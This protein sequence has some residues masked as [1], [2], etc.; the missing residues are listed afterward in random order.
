MN[1]EQQIYISSIDR[2]GKDEICIKKT[3]REDINLPAHEHNKHQIIFTLSGTL[4]VQID[5][6]S[7]FVPEHHIAW[8]PKNV[9]HKLSSNN[10]KIAIEIFFVDMS[11]RKTN[12]HKEF[13]IYNTDR[14]TLENIRYIADER[15]TISRKNDEDLYF[16]T[17]SFFGLLNKMNS[18]Y[19][20]P[21]R[22]LVVPR[23]ERLQPV[24][25]Y[26][27]THLYEDLSIGTIANKFGFS[28]RNLSRILSS[29]GIRYTSY[30]NYQRITRAI[31][32]FADGNKTMAEIAY[33]VGYNT[34]NNF[35]RV[36]KKIMGINPSTFTTK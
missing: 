24:L 29:S 9:V 34:P 16:Y 2:S 5:N 4:H 23:D 11:M 15:Q 25:N 10:N 22:A 13:E 36:F 20:L 6:I 26:I 8:I 30:I 31:E 7:Y 27:N 1:K 35:N 3:S 28:V 33:E 12:E 32:F 17:I 19:S 18:T 14:L 21:L